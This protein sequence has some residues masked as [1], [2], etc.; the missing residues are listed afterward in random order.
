[1]NDQTIA[2]S[3]NEREKRKTKLG[4]EGEK[5]AREEKKHEQKEWR[6]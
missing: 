4:R 6:K 3:A 1:M 2:T 5:N